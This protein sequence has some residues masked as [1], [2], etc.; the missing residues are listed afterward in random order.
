MTD[1]ETIQLNLPDD[2]KNKFIA[3]DTAFLETMKEQGRDVLS[4]VQLLA[5]LHQTA[6]EH[7][8]EKLNE[9]IMGMLKGKG[10]GEA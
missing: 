1:T 7:M 4:S 3:A 8:T 5:A 6:S 2:V 10:E 9:L